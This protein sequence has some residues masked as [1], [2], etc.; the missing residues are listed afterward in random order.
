MIAAG[1]VDVVVEAGLQIY[2]IAALIPIINAAGGKVTTWQDQPV[3][4]LAHRDR[5]QILA[6]ANPTLHEKSRAILGN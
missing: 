1:F 2:D 3:R 6:A 5:L 4:G